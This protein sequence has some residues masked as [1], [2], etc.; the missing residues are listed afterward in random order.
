MVSLRSDVREKYC[1]VQLIPPLQDW[2]SSRRKGYGTIAVRVFFNKGKSISP[3]AL[4]QRWRSQPPP[5]HNTRPVLE[6][7]LLHPSS[8]SQLLFQQPHFKRSTFQCTLSP[9]GEKHRLEID[10]HLP[11]L[12][13]N[14]LW[15]SWKLLTILCVSVCVLLLFLVIIIKGPL[16]LLYKT[17]SSISLAMWDQCFHWRGSLW[18]QLLCCLWQRFYFVFLQRR[19]NRAWSDKNYVVGCQ[20]CAT[21]D[22]PLKW[23]SWVT[24]DI[25]LNQWRGA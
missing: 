4:L 22:N 2:T 3:E 20:L 19:K 14:N 9:L 1:R 13:R 23:Q 10:L 21:Q 24:Q 11:R 5:T 25:P 7:R 17:P 16:S 6:A 18:M 15:T 12:E 8:W